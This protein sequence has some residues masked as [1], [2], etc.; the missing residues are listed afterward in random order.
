MGKKKYFSIIIFALIFRLIL[1]FLVWHPDLRNHM[2]WGERFWEYGVKDFYTQNV[3]NFTWPNQPPGTIYLFA[4]V[5]KL[6]EFIFSIFWWINVH[7]PPFPSNLMY[8]LE[9]N[10]YPVLLKLPAI[11]ADFG[12]AYI[13]YKIISNHQSPRYQPVLGKPTTNHSKEIAMLGVVFFLFNPVIWY[14]SSVWGQYD[15][16]INFLALFSFYLLIQKKLTLALLT[17][18]LSLYTKASLA[19]FVPIFLIVTFKQRYG[20]K[21]IMSAIL[22]TFLILGIITIPFTDDNPYIW[23]YNL[24]KDKV[25]TQQLQV[26]TANAF[27]LWAAIAGI[28]ELPHTLKLGFLSYHAWGSALFITVLT[29]LLYKLYKKTNAANIFWILVLVSLSSFM[30]LTNMHERYL[31]PFFPVFTVIAGFYGLWS[32]YWVFSLINLLNLYNFWWTP[33]IPI[34]I[35]LMSA[36]DRLAPRLL[37]LLSF[38]LFL[39][40][41]KYYLRLFRQ[42]KI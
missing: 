1:A 34:V 13:I 3:W 25:F 24:Y 41:Y 9:L 14:N 32:F 2:D 18:A 19:I 39:Y 37:G 17:Y 33:E 42:G 8:Y 28:H 20:W 12:I 40:L 31:Y 16:V 11:L 21:S 15:S 23:L 4:G 35:N 38:L 22:I 27:N 10:L 29:P 5:R 26:I 36:G 30:L 6:Y 7:I